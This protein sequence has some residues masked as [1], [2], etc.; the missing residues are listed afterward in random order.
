MSQFDIVATLVLSA[1]MVIR[2]PLRVNTLHQAASCHHHTHRL[3][4]RA[5][6]ACV[7]TPGRGRR[8]LALL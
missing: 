7:T 6:M 4:A 1:Q 2:L 8:L 5:Y 3:R